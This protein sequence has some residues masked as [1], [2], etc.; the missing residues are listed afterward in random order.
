VEID[1][2]EVSIQE[3]PSYDDL[4]DA[5]HELAERYEMICHKNKLGRKVHL[6]LSTK[7][8]ALL[9]ENELLANEINM[10]KS[11]NDYNKNKDLIAKNEQLTKD[12]EKFTLGRK[13]L[14]MLLGTQTQSLTKHGLGYM[15]GKQK[16]ATSYFVKHNNSY[17]KK[18]S[19]SNV[20]VPKTSQVW[21]PKA[22][23]QG[24]KQIWVPKS[25]LASLHVDQSKEK[26][27]MDT[28]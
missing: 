27:Q 17:V 28:R 24:P 25:S 3:T 20:W 9:K 10:L 7:H 8:D 12:L 18:V 2:D 14:D 5:F 16:K 22:N 21:V 13:M 11:T 26:G 15:G 6:E 4:L 1:D 19:L 23:P